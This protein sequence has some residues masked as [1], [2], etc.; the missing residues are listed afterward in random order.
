MDLEFEET[1]GGMVDS[2]WGDNLVYNKFKIGFIL[3]KPSW[4]RNL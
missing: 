4:K 3:D 1:I 2:Y